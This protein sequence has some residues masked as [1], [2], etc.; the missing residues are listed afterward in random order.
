M[1]SG[2]PTITQ[3]VL[4]HP[5]PHYPQCILFYRAL[6]KI[7]LRSNLAYY[8]NLSGKH[9]NKSTMKRRGCQV[10]SECKKM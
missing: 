7:I 9:K 6:G 5:S 8:A 1:R 2:L 4:G 10:T 3:L